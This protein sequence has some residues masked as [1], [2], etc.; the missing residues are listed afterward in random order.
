MRSRG[1]TGKVDR[2]IR[3]G[4]HNFRS[5]R[6]PLPGRQA[7]AGLAMFDLHD[8]KVARFE[9]VQAWDA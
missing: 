1:L 8:G 5:H 4:R 6:L 2:L 7:L 9:P 3:E